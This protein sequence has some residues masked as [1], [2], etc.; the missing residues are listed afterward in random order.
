MG[1]KTPEDI[2][3]RALQHCGASLIVTLQDDDK[4]AQQ[5]AQCYD[6]LRRAELRRNVWTF[7]VKKAVLYPLNTSLTNLPIG[8]ATA[9]PTTPATLTQSLPTLKL[10]AQPWSAAQVYPF[11]RVVSYG[12]SVWLSTATTSANQQPG[13]DASTNW[14]TYFGSKVVVPY[15][16]TVAYYFGDLVYVA[17]GPATLVFSSLENSNGSTNNAATGTVSNN[18]LN[19]ATWSSAVTY[20]VGSVVLDAAG[21]AW[22]SRISNNVNLQPGVYGAWS[23]APTYV[24]GAL[25]IATDGLLYQAATGGN[26]QNPANGA[27]PSYWTALGAPGSWPMW[28]TNTTY[29]KAAVVMGSDGMLYQAVQAANTGHQPVGAAYNP[30]TPATNW[31]VPLGQQASWVANF[32]APVTNASWLNQYATLDMVNIAYPIGAG[33]SQQ[34][35]T[36]NV[37]MLPHGY[38]RQ[39]PQDPKRGSMSFLGAPSGM[40]YSD[41]ELDGDCII[42]QQAYPIILRFVADVTQVSKMDDM[43]CEGLGARVAME[44]CETLTQS[45]SK[46]GAIGAVYKKFMDDARTVNGI[47]QGATEPPVDDWIACRV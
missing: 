11:G 38:L 43:F 32:N 14:D 10:I 41:W 19:P 29:A 13:L 2:A 31:W 21:F 26:N 20:G 24:T 8:T 28:N 3:N 45:G 33:P 15:D 35:F 1:F 18:P 47:E 9:S 37:F 5:I 40:Q 23:S 22:Y 4:G 7:A 39:A 44:V 6:G 30:N 17:D 42:S 46:L 27:S 34:E 16:P 12:G 36:K 25:V